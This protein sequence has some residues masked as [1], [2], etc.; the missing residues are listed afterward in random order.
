MSAQASFRVLL[1]SGVR[2]SHMLARYQYFIPTSTHHHIPTSPDIP[3]KESLYRRHAITDRLP[4]SASIENNRRLRMALAPPPRRGS[5]DSIPPQG[6]RRWSEHTLQSG[7]WDEPLEFRTLRE[8]R[9]KVWKF[10]SASS[11]RSRWI[12]V[13]PRLDALVVM[14]L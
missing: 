4:T 1:T 7:G 6:H 14:G 9:K 13:F 5:H 8:R 11:N 2:A 10:S 3:G 12:R